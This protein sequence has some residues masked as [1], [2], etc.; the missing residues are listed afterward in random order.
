MLVSKKENK[1]EKKIYVK[2][3]LEKTIRKLDDIVEDLFVGENSETPILSKETDTLVIITDEEPNDTLLKS[4]RYKNDNEGIFIVVFNI[5]RLQFNV[6]KHI[7]SPDIRVIGS[8]EL[9]QLKD[10]IKITSLSQF[11]EISR[12]DP[13]AMS[14]F[15]RPSQVCH[16]IRDCPTS[17]KEDYYRVCV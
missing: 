12:F 4:L 15:M 1:K 7:L 8:E 9:E 5:R 2:Y 13:L 16:I 11:P 3:H 10:K 17:V 14:I 6:R